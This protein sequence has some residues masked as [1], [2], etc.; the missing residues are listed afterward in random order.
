M[1]AGTSYQLPVSSFQP[2]A[3]SLHVADNWQLAS[4]NW[5]LVTG[6]WKLVTGNW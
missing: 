1:I 6:N 4:G 2:R 3:I 5:K